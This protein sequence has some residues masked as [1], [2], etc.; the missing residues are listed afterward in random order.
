MLYF[1]G[2]IYT[3]T[4]FVRWPNYYTN[5]GSAG[6]MSAGEVRNHCV[7]GQKKK[8][9]HE[10]SQSHSTDTV[11]WQHYAQVVSVHFMAKPLS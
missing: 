11:V 8:R 10:R 3:N 1:M 2:S 5:V 6:V 9:P 4:P 7:R